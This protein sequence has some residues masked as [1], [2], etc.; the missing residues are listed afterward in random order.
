MSTVFSIIL[1]LV[2]ILLIRMGS[3]ALKDS[4]SHY[5]YGVETESSHKTF[6]WV[7]IL[8]GCALAVW[9]SLLLAG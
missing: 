9:A 8:A 3:G 5:E 1:F 6:S 2:A 7:T 4:S